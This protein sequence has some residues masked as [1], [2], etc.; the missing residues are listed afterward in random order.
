MIFNE[1]LRVI[2]NAK[3]NGLKVVEILEKDIPKGTAKKLREKGYQVVK[4]A[5][6]GHPTDNCSISVSWS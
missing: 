3:K 2:D 1:V 6:V 4:T 5:P